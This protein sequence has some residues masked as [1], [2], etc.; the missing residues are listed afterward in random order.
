MAINITPSVQITGAS[1]QIKAMS[2]EYKKVTDRLKEFRTQVV[3]ANRAIRSM[4]DAA[5]DAARALRSMQ[6][7]AAIQTVQVRRNVSSNMYGSPIGPQL[8]PGAAPWQF[9]P[10]AIGP[11]PLAA[12]PVLTS[13]RRPPLAF[14]NNPLAGMNAYAQGAASGNP[15][16]I[17]MFSRYSGM[18]RSQKQGA[19]AAKMHQAFGSG[20]MGSFVQD[21]MG[22]DVMGAAVRALSSLGPEGI[23][24]AAAL[25]AVAGAAALAVA[26]VRQWT[27]ALV[28]GG[29]GVSVARAAAVAG[30]GYGVDLGGVGRNLMSGYG[31]IAAAMAGVNP[32]G[33]PFGDNNYNAKGLQVLR[34]TREIAQRQGVDAA[35]RYAELAGAPEL[36]N[37]ALS[38]KDVFDAATERRPTGRSNEAMQAITDFGVT[39]NTLKDSIAEFVVNFTPLIEIIKGV[40]NAMKG[41]IIVL[42]NLSNFFD[43]LISKI[44]ELFG[45]KSDRLAD[46][47]DRNTRATED[48]TQATREGNYG[49]GQ[50]VQGAVPPKLSPAMNPR[51]G[52]VPSGVM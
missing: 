25:A 32:F 41:V 30:G 46:S 4:A 10:S 9:Y 26:S 22:G 35:R 13:G 49:G 23:A 2:E 51:Y 48:N 20:P 16:S 28:A 5:K 19:M 47:M 15:H 24:A 42:R 45:I 18:F 36:A 29:G 34:K 17:A 44:R 21:A 7:A 43:M 12:P 3:N 14:A 33:G 31:P 37:V 50:R 11:T 27:A 8:P 6:R 39:F 38:S 52:G 1:K 40:T